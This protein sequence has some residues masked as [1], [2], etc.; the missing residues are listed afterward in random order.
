MD[1][2]SR[3]AGAVVGLAPAGRV[4]RAANGRSQWRSTSHSRTLVPD[5]ASSGHG[6][7]ARQAVSVNVLARA[8]YHPNLRAWTYTYAVSSDPESRNDV[9]YFAIAPITALLKVDAPA[10]WVHLFYPYQQGDSGVVWAAVDVGRL[11]SGCVDTRNIPPSEYA[12]HPGDSLVFSLTSHAPPFPGPRRVTWFAQG[13][14]T[15]PD[16][17]KEIED[18]PGE[19]VFADAVTGTAI[20]PDTTSLERIGAASKEQRRRMEHPRP[21]RRHG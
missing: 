19:M 16:A 20:G 12:I 9:D 15:L 13:F 14:D 4:A 7:R 17:E 18:V 1:L 3:V 10:H 21:T 5:S 11:P 2:R 6:I 8:T